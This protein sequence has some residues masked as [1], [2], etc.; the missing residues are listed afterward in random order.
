MPRPQCG[1]WTQQKKGS[2]EGLAILTNLLC[3]IVYI[4]T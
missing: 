1:F 3:E 2:L 4:A